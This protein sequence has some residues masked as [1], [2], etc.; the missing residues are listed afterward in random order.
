MH[1][2]EKLKV[3]IKQQV[4]VIKT[5]EL[6]KFFDFISMSSDFGDVGS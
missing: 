2:W 4:S 6:Y 1:A 5:H 3:Y